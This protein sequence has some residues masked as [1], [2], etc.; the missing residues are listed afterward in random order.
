MQLNNP[1]R[2]AERAGMTVVADFRSRDVAA[3]GQGAPLVPAFHAALFAGGVHRVVINVG[4]IANI[5]DLPP[6]GPVRGFDTGPGNALLDLWHARHRGAAFDNDGAWA[7]SGR[8]DADLLD[9]SRAEPYFARTPPKST[10]PRPL[11]RGLARPE[12]RRAVKVARRRRAGD[13][14]FADRALD[15]RRD[16]HANARAPPKCWSAAAA[17]TIRR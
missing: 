1:A 6:G 12:A 14:A 8:V 2:V 7:A 15:R 5:T 4:G 13:A 10:R 3:G 11:P 16:S 9:D 17:Q